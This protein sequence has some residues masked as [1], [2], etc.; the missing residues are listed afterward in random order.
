MFCL[1][2]ISELLKYQYNVSCSFVALSRVAN[3]FALAV[4]EARITPLRSQVIA[5]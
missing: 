2:P 4:T 1:S 3:C 5:E